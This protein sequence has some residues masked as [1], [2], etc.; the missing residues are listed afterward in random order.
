[1]HLNMVF[2]RAQ[3]PSLLHRSLHAVA[4]LTLSVRLCSNVSIL[5]S[6]AVWKG[7][8]FLLAATIFTCL[9]RIAAAQAHDCFI[10]W[11]FSLSISHLNLHTL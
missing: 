9:A 6:S 2:H 1:M 8:D 5:Y 7:F 4:L 3:L 10:Y 11:L